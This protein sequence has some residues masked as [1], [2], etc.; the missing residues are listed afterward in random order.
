M[1]SYIFIIIS[2]LLII[3]PTVNSIFLSELGAEQL[4]LGYILVAA[5]ALLSSL[6][7]SK[8]LVKYQLNRIIKSTLAL[9][10]IILILLATLLKFG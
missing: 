5:A 10:I 3:K 1:F 9:S 2:V 6:F 7:Y 8:L 4:P